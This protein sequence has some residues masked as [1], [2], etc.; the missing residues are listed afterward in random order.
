MDLTPSLSGR[1]R[2]PPR[3]AGQQAGSPHPYTG[4]SHDIP[5]PFSSCS[6]LEGQG[7]ETIQALRIDGDTLVVDLSYSGGCERHRF[8][9]C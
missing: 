1:H 6:A 3:R 5:E 4:G 9:I 8:E 7:G 2:H